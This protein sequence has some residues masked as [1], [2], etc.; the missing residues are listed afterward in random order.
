MLDG[1]ELTY[2]YQINARG[3]AAPLYVGG[4]GDEDGGMGQGGMGGMGGMGVGVSVFAGFYVTCVEGGRRRR[5]FLMGLLQR[6][7]R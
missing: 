4:V 5:E 2:T 6:T 1:I 7:H 3:C